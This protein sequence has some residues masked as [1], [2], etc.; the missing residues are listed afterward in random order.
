MAARQHTGRDREFSRL[1]VGV[2][3]RSCSE[4][5]KKKGGGDAVYVNNKWCNPGHITVKERVCSPDIELLAASL[6]PYYLPREFSQ[7]II[8]VVYIPPMA[9]AL[10]AADVISAVTTRLQTLHH[11]SFL[12]ISGD[13]NHVTLKATLPTFKQFVNCKTREN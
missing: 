6:H 11:K 7:T 5:G 4:S 3:E 12:A 13:F 9:D 1:S 8:I 2:G 10:R